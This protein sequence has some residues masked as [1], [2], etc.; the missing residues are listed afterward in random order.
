MCRPT[1]TIACSPREFHIQYLLALCG[2]SEY[3]TNVAAMALKYISTAIF[4]VITCI[5][6]T[7][8]HLVF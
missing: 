5:N 6:P 8:L 3:F 4:D 1:H 7:L 2:I